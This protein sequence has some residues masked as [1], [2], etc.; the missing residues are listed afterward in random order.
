MSLS[1]ALIQI[2]QSTRQLS[3]DERLWL[4]ERLVRGL[5]HCSRD[6]VLV[7][8]TTLAEMAGDP[9]IRRELAQIANGFAPTETDGLKQI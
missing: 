3:Y 4:I 9:E 8:D 6:A 2:E 5:R 1:I 7:L